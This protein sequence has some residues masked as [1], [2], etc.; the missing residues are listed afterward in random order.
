M[1][2]DRNV[3]QMEVANKLLLDMVK[4]QRKNN[5]NTFKIFITTLICYTLILISMVIG[6]FVYESQF[7]V[8]DAIKETSTKTI[9]QEVSGDGSEINNVEGNMYK[10]NA[11]HN[12]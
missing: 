5:T 7:E 8:T 10:D 6:F 1:D 2:E 12:E 3:E 4:S 11:I 9:E